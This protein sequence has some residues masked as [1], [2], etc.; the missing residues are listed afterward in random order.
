MKTGGSSETVKI[1]TKACVITLSVSLVVLFI[2]FCWVEG[3]HAGESPHRKAKADI[4]YYSTAIDLYALDHE[5][6][7][8]QSLNELV[9]K[10][11]SYARE[12]SKDPW[13]H[14]YVYSVDGNKYTI[15]SAGPDG[16]PG[17]ADDVTSK[18]TVKRVEDSP[19]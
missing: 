7:L 5:N 17:T 4:T 13:G 6:K 19:R 14:D 8:P 11:R 1:L 3:G 12:I 10:K 15:F 2:T 9:G 16:K 18:T